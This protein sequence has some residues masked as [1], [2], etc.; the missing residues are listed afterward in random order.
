M[1]DQNLIQSPQEAERAA[2]EEA[3]RRKA[4]EESLGIAAG[5]IRNRF[6]LPLHEM[7]IIATED[8]PE[9]LKNRVMR[10]F[11]PIRDFSDRFQKSAVTEEELKKMEEL[12]VPVEMIASIRGRQIPREQIDDFLK[13]QVE[14]ISMEVENS[15]VA[16]M[17]R[18]ESGREISMPNK[19][20]S[21][22]QIQ[23]E[24]NRILEREQNP[25]A[26]KKI[27]R[28]S[29]DLN[30]LKKAND[31]NG[32]HEKGD[33]YLRLVES[34]LDNPSLKSF[35]QERGLNIVS[36]ARVGGDEFDAIITAENSISESGLND[37]QAEIKRR[38]TEKKEAA[39]I[40]DF[41]D[42]KVILHYAG[43]TGKNEEVF[44]RKSDDEKRAVLDEIKKEIPS[45]FEFVANVSCGA[46]TL[47]EAM[48]DPENDKDNENKINPEE[49]YGRILK[50]M[51]GCLFTTSDSRMQKN[52]EVFKQSLASGNEHERMMYRISTRNIEEFKRVRLEQKKDDKISL[53]NK[54]SVARKDLYDLD[55]LRASE[56]VLEVKK[57]EIAVIEEDLKRVDEDLK[58][59]E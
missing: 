59:I 37:V 36:V 45:D 25:E 7:V 55:Q 13:K 26:L 17:G 27:A 57:Q 20:F 22:L 4:L 15:F 32:S 6:K 28:I 52:K 47:Y 2:Y 18:D 8:L 42:E 56:A 9:E 58:K 14:I 34:V 49:D 54:L 23:Q 1:S 48:V 16:D 5:K 12:N 24:I 53:L 44:Y 43:I 19:N 33:A 10:S 50:K 11:E 21:R 51:M 35:A 46:A 39:N 29:I 31:Y 41:K 30:N 38:I 3:E 40:V